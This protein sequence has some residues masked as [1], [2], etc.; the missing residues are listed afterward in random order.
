MDFSRFLTYV[1]F[2]LSAKFNR[3][4]IILGGLE[5]TDQKTTFFQKDPK[6]VIFR[7]FWWFT[8]EIVDFIKWG[9]LGKKPRFSWFSLK[10]HS[11]RKIGFFSQ[12]LVLRVDRVELG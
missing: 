5:E 3:F 8:R 4:F 11:S 10:L 6:I 12:F 7:G 2:S 9:K 1:N